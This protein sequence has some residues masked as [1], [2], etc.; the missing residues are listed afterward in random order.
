MV[1]LQLDLVWAGEA[2]R[3]PQLPPEQMNYG[4]ISKAG[5]YVKMKSV[6]LN[7]TERR[8]FW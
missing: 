5:V 2:G 7:V 3:R 6:F 8:S 1:Q 4:Y